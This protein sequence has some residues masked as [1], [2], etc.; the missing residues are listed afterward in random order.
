MG[1]VATTLSATVDA[2][3]FLLTFDLM[4]VTAVARNSRRD[5]AS[6]I[7]QCT[8]SWEK[9]PRSMVLKNVFLLS[10]KFQDG[11]MFVDILRVIGAATYTSFP[12]L[13]VWEKKLKSSAMLETAVFFSVA[14]ATSC[15]KKKLSI[16]E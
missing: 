13:R 7:N 16:F 6:I 2:P 12:I 5:E 14:R 11:R 8:I 1:S 4:N 15:L 10:T 3:K 9:S